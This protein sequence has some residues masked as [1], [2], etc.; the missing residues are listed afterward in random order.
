MDSRSGAHV[1][2]QI[3]ELLEAKGAQRFKAKAYIR[4]ARAVVSLDT[5]DLGALLQSGELA[6]TSGIGPATLSVIR[7]LVE[8]GESSYLAQLREG[9][10]E[11]LVGLMRVK[12]LTPARIQLIHNELGIENAEE[13]AAAARD[14]RL[15]TLPK[16]GE[17]TAAVILRSLE[18]RKRSA[19][20]ARYPVAAIEAEILRSSVEKHPGVS[21]AIIAGSVRR[22]NEIAADLDIAAE[23]TDDPVKVADSFARSPGVK[24]AARSADKKSAMIE[25]VDGTLFDIH[26]APKAGF[27]VALWR[28]T[29]SQAHVDAVIAYLEK[30]GFSLDGVT[31]I[32]KN[33]KP[34]RIATED[35]FYKAIG[36]EPI[37]PEL[38]EGRGE[39]EAAARSSLPDLVSFE[40]IQG[41]LHSHSEYSDGT[42]TIA[43]MAK[44]ARER[45]WSYIGISDHSEAAFYA[46]GLKRD[47][48]LR[49]HDEIDELNAKSRCF[50]ILKGIE[51]DILADGRLDYDADLLD[52]FDFVIGSIHSRFS[53]ERDKMTARVLAAMDDP[54]LTILA[55]PTGRLLLSR[56][57]YSIDLDAVIEKAAEQRVAIEINADPHRLDMDWRHCHH[58]KDLGVIFEIGPDAHSIA[59]LDNVHFG[60]GMA[61]KGWLEAGDILNARSV[62]EVLNFARA[63][64]SR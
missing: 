33:G 29:G 50:T 2:S 34:V 12:G 64:K 10:P 19:K 42:A 55:H 21:R 39:V 4:A 44:A 31:L 13:L 59:S 62:K 8:T 49:Q 54:H 63:R 57:G 30:K 15:A 56:E 58:A 53:M 22:F 20:M 37:P 51:A 6:A 25:F 3:G 23:C 60:I 32:G 11:G 5:D 16:I 9:V 36:L 41:V 17:K 43:E 52:R 61:R 40:A 7:D 24:S 47:D 45:G 35:A 18:F 46:G 14:G 27:P 38:R 1:L 28:A 48:V 26:C